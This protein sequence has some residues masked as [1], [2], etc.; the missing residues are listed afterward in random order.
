MLKKRKRLPSILSG[1][2]RSSCAAAVLFCGL[3]ISVDSAVA[4]ELTGNL[5]ADPATTGL[6]TIITGAE[7][8]SKAVGFTTPAGTPYELNSATF[9]MQFIGDAAEPGAIPQVALWSDAA[10]NPGSQLSV[11]TNPGVLGA[12]DFYTFTAASP[13]PLLASTSYWMLVNGSPSNTDPTMDAFYWNAESPS[14]PHSGVAAF[15]GYRFS[16]TTTPPTSNS[17]VFNNVSV[18]ATLVPEPSTLVTLLFGL[19]IFGARRFAG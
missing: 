12:K 9:V 13:I 17:S 5:P 18:N 4:V 7:T 10:G 1:A 3:A 15:L 14:I 11:L 16:G 2:L 8:R 6:G 19:A